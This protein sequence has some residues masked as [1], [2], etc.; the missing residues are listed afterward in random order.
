MSVGEY[1]IAARILAKHF[2]DCLKDA[3]AGG[4][5]RV[6]L[7]LSNNSQ[8]QFLRELPLL[9]VKG[10]LAHDA[11][12]FEGMHSRATGWNG[13]SLAPNARENYGKWIAASG[14]QAS[15]PDVAKALAE[16]KSG[17]SASVRKSPRK[18]TRK[19]K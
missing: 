19:A 6:S 10:T 11:K 2:P 17:K 14:F 15:A 13:F 16:L 8:K 7:I 12:G 9:I 4:V 5:E 3:A 1:H 18:A